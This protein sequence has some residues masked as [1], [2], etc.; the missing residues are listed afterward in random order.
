MILSEWT[1]RL[2]AKNAS[3]H[4][5][6]VVRLF[7]S[8]DYAEPCLAFIVTSDTELDRLNNSI[9]RTLKEDADEMSNA[10][11]KRPQ[12]PGHVVYFPGVQVDA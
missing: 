10:G 8:G 7:M 3:L 6:R 11:R 12:A 4:D 2:I 5:S 9:F 1:V